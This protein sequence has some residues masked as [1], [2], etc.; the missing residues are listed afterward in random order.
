LR[1]YQNRYARY[2]RTSGNITLAAS[3]NVWANVDTGSDLTLNASTGDVIEIV[4]SALLQS[5]AVETFFD[6]VTL[7][8]GSPVNSFGFDAPPQ[9]P[10]TSFGIAGWYV[11]Q[12]VQ[13]G[14]SSSA[15]RTL[16]AGDISSGTVTL[17]LRYAG[18]ANTARTMS[19]AASQPFELWARNHGPVTT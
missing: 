4:I 14:L 16:V 8:G 7:V 13:F 1:S 6:V 18:T 3:L 12:N 17:R 2:K 5:A 9:N 15:F 11:N 19:A 10:G